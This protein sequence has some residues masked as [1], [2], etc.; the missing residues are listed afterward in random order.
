MTPTPGQEM[1]AAREALGK[2]TSE[3]AKVT[4]ITV[5]QIEGL[6][7][8]Q[9]DCIPAPMYVR[10]FMKLY[11]Q[12]LGLNPEPLL[13]RYEEMRSPAAEGAG[14]SAGKPKEAARPR[15]TS[16]S[17][18]RAAEEGSGGPDKGGGPVQKGR[19]VVRAV[20]EGLGASTEERFSPFARIGEVFS[21]LN[22]SSRW[23]V[24]RWMD[25]KT[26]RVTAGV[27]LGLM[28]VLGLGFCGRGGGES[29]DPEAPAPTSTREASP[30]SLP[31]IDD[32]LLPSPAPVLPE[33]PRTLE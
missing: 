25:S 3:M 15:P 4:R 21:R 14:A 22:F 20:L 33:L 17:P 6:E 27:L 1:R 30:G 11:A 18:G 24:S 10:G 23:D 26:A 13:M 12:A 19:G 9:Y 7:A 28:L 29:E 5:Q 8:D 32:P 16:D 2:S 31:E